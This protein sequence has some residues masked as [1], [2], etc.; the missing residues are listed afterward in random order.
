MILQKM[1]DWTPYDSR[2]V[3]IYRSCAGCG[4]R[5]NKVQVHDKEMDHAHKECHPSVYTSTHCLLKRIDFPQSSPRQNT[6]KSFY[7]G[8]AS[9]C[10]RTRKW[11]ASLCVLCGR[12]LASQ[13]EKRSLFMFIS[14]LPLSSRNREFLEIL[15][16][17]GGQ[18]MRQRGNGQIGDELQIRFTGYLIQAVKRT[19][20]DYLMSLY[21]DNVSR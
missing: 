16:F 10:R 9:A 15:D 1:N 2:P 20:R 14:P 6:R 17:Y 3:T 11:K 13:P 5:W 4:F 18:V 7:K 8:K 21:K 19:Q 12:L